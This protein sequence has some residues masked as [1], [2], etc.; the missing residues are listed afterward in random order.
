[1]RFIVYTIAVC[2]ALANTA[3]TSALDTM[4]AWSRVQTLRDIHHPGA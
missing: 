3:F 2:A 1:M 4:Y